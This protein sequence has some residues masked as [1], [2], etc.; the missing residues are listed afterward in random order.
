MK[1]NNFIKISTLKKKDKVGWWL[2]EDHR[3]TRRGVRRVQ[4]DQL[5]RGGRQPH[6]TKGS[7]RRRVGGGSGGGARRVGASLA[8]VEWAGVPR[9]VPACDQR[10]LPPRASVSSSVQRGL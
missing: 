7:E 2:K 8:H 1:D 5:R 9:P 6:R 3:W 10:H 4:G